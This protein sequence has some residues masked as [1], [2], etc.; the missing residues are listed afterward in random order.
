MDPPEPPCSCSNQSKDQIQQENPI[1]KNEQLSIKVDYLEKR[2]AHLSTSNTDLSSRLVHSEEEKLKIS[3]ELVEEK[4]QINKMRAQFEEEMFELKNEILNQKDAITELQ[5]ERDNLLGKLQSVE[6][7]LQTGEKSD[8]ELA[9]LKSNYLALAEAHHKELAQ[10]K[11]LSAELLALAQAQDVLR[12]QLAEQHQRARDTSQDLHGELDRV[13]ALVG[14][15]LQSRIKPEDLATLNKGQKSMEKT[16]LGNQ[17]EMKDMLEKLKR[18]YEEEQRKLEEKIGV[19][20]REQQIQNSQQN[21]TEKSMACSCCLSQLKE[22]KE[23]ISK[24]QLQVKE[25]HELYRAR[26]VCYL[27][28]ITEFVDGVGGGK[29]ASEGNKLRAFVDDMLRDVRA[30]YRAREEQLATATRAYKKSLQRTTKTHHALICAYRG[31]RQQILAKPDERL[32]PGPPETHFTL[33]ATDPREESKKH[34]HQIEHNKEQVV[35]DQVSVSKMPTNQEMPNPEQIFQESWSVIRKQLKE[36]TDSTLGMYAK[37]HKLL[38]T[39]ATFAEAQASQLQDYIDKHLDRYKQEIA[40]LRQLR[41]KQ[42]AS[43]THNNL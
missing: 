11:E 41:G 4:L 36:I 28:D 18:S 13:R 39:R 24:L 27:R 34:S 2:V 5:T 15:L 22:A 43:G 29:M 37:E 16:L 30:S 20:G 8:R 42:E 17:E 32:E 26:L 35:R 6:T 40:R 3:K 1:E 10:S 19:M 25:L 31:Q 14:R 9:S 38:S 23:E 12:S 33:E 7:H 21:V